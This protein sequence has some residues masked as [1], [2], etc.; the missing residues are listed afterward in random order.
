RK[1]QN[2]ELSHGVEIDYRAEDYG[3]FG[4]RRSNENHVSPCDGRQCKGRKAAGKVPPTL[5][6]MLA[7]WPAARFAIAAAEQLA[8]RSWTGS[9]IR[10]GS[11]AAPVLESSKISVMERISRMKPATSPVRSAIVLALTASLTLG[12]GVATLQA[13]A[14]E[15]TL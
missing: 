4:P 12:L 3:G 8:S 13:Q 11:L 6:L 1:F 15:R 14:Q 7:V 9:S 10:L 2:G 5:N